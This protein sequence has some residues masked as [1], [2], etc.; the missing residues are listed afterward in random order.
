[1][2][3]F[4]KYKDGSYNIPQKFVQILHTPFQALLDQVGVNLTLPDK[5]T[6]EGQDSIANH[7]V[8]LD[9]IKKGIKLVETYKDLQG[10]AWNYFHEQTKEPRDR[11][12]TLD[13]KLQRIVPKDDHCNHSE[14]DNEDQ[15]KDFIGTL[16]SHVSEQLMRKRKPEIFDK[17]NKAVFKKQ[18]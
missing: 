12:F 2:S 10:Y 3:D 7:F 16:L 9:D 13:L 5:L 4:K 8:K 18:I 11:S 15:L 14:E 17:I 6:K 1:M